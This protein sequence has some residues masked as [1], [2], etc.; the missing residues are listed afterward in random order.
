MA[1]MGT[2]RQ[3]LTFG[4][5]VSSAHDIY[6]SGEGVFDAPERAVEMVTVPGRNGAIP[7]DQGYWKNIRV[8]YP[9]FFWDKTS[10]SSFA[11]AFAAFRS[12]VSAL[13]G[14]Q[15]ISDTINPNEYRMGMLVEG[16]EAK[17]I[18][19]NTAADFNLVFDCKPQRF[20]TSGET[21]Q[22]I[23]SS[24][25]TITNP[26]LFDAQPLL[27]LDGYGKVAFNGYEVEVYNTEVGA[28]TISDATEKGQ[29]IIPAMGTTLT[30][31]YEYNPGSFNAG[32][33]IT[34]AGLTF[35][36]EISPAPNLAIISTTGSG[37]A[38]VTVTAGKHNT[39]PAIKVAFPDLT[40]T[41]G[42]DQTFTYSFY[43]QFSFT[44]NGSTFT[45]SV[46]ASHPATFTITHDATNGTITIDWYFG[47]TNTNYYLSPSKFTSI[48][49]FDSLAG[50]STYV[51]IS[52]PVYIDC[53][54]GEAYIIQGG[55]PVSVNNSVSIGAD[56]PVL[57]PGANAVTYDN[58]FNSVKITPRWWQL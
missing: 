19:Y 26:T 36:G 38:G 11:S 20:L 56:L 35:Y 58:T 25:D 39:T 30:E 8:T 55:E 33:T 2:G 29:Q 53:E 32:D 22:T 42:T 24:G 4:N 6:I 21:E 46:S 43:G 40:F 47:N 52:D 49:A 16:L 57:A 37:L 15:R 3:V 27:K 31:V 23:A 44:R 13:T 5:V 28:V 50:I 51:V 18:K 54:I 48:M 9:A 7:V 34:L 14:Y 45:Y 41:A 1:V 12:A 10:L 17:V